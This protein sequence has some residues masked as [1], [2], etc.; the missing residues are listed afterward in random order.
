MYGTTVA[1]G[2]AG[3]HDGVG[4]IEKISHP[5]CVEL[6]A[7]DLDASERFYTTLL[8]MA[9]DAD[10]PAHPSRRVLRA[11]DIDS[12]LPEIVLNRADSASAADSVLLELESSSELLDRYLIARLLNAP[13]TS[14]HSSNGCLYARV[15]DPDG[16]RIEL[17]AA[18]SSSP[19]PGCGD[20][21]ARKEDRRAKRPG[22]DARGNSRRNGRR[23]D[24]PR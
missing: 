3:R 24:R 6:H 16:H 23:S 2:V 20:R 5:A 15:R 13:A 10:A 19:T 21:W 18:D 17:R 14:L 11:T 9:P 12:T 1:D 8:G 4:R 7:N 22:G